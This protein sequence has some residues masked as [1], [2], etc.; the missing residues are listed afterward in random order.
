LPWI[1]FFFVL[2]FFGVLA[3]N[4]LFLDAATTQ[5]ALARYLAPVLVAAILFFVGTG[6]NLLKSL[7]LRTWVKAAAGGYAG[8]LIILFSIQSLALVRNPQIA[9]TGFKRQRQA[10]VE[11]LEALDPDAPIITNNPEMVYLMANRPAYMWPIAFD[12]Y[13]LE[14]R[15]DYD[16]QLE[17]TRKKLRLG[18]V[19]VVFGWPMGTEE[20]VF[21][22]LEAERMETFIDVHFFGY[23]NSESE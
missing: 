23:L 5:G 21:D 18:G 20:L 16:A 1:L 12:S 15:V 4:S 10:A 19:L 2:G 7:Q 17:S 22:V 8:I 11:V 3:V 9:Y 13:T 14:E 6:S